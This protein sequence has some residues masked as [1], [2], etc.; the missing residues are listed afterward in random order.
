MLTVISPGYAVNSGTLLVLF[1]IPSQYLLRECRNISSGSIFGA[2]NK[3]NTYFNL[4]T[5]FLT[6]A[7]FN[8]VLVWS[9]FSC[10]HLAN[11]YVI[12]RVRLVAW[13]VESLTTT[14]QRY[15]LS[16]RKQMA[17]QHSIV[18]P[19]ILTRAKGV[20]HPIILLISS[21]IT[22]PKFSYCFS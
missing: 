22:M 3:Q 18:S 8:N 4:K 6:L 11:K 19:E 9:V 2:I 21:L 12:T 16:Y 10:C 15:K 17:R 14:T 1:E 5:L 7:P 20:V 13:A